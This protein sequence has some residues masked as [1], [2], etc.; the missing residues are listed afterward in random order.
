MGRFASALPVLVHISKSRMHL[1][2]GNI[3]TFPL[4]S[5]KRLH[6]FLFKK[7]VSPHR[8]AYNEGVPLA[9]DSG[10]WATPKESKA[11]HFFAPG[12]S[13]LTRSVSEAGRLSLAYAS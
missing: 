13:I 3:V 11:G 1:W 12:T 5:K 10:D 4:C 7:F 8:P 2:I 9:D 6:F